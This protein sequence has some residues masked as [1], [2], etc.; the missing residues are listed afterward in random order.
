MFRKT[1]SDALKLR[2]QEHIIF[3]SCYKYYLR[4]TASEVKAYFF[5]LLLS[6]F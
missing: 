3:L 4:M 2:R 6:E 1:I 5:V